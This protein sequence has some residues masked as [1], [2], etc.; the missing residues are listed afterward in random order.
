MSSRTATPGKGRTE[1]AHTAGGGGTN[2]VGNRLLARLGP[3]RVLA[4]GLLLLLSGAVCQVVAQQVGPGASQ[5]VGQ[6]EPVIVDITSV[7]PDV[8]EPNSVITIAYR[9]ARSPSDSPPVRPFVLVYIEGE[10]A[11]V[12]GATS[13]L[14]HARV[15]VFKVGGKESIVLSGDLLTREPWTTFL[16]SVQQC[17][18]QRP[19]DSRRRNGCGSREL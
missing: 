1:M 17:L 11:D 14:V 2:A 18:S 3:R 8:A 9:L 19:L 12:L 10:K 13:D 15:P 4:S 5:A 16:P 7:K 6:T